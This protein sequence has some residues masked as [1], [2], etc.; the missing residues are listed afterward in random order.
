MVCCKDGREEMLKHAG[1]SY[2][3]NGD[4]LMR[5]PSDI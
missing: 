1:F 3:T 4:I 5:F 2:E